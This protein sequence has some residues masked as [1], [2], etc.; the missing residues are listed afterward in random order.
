MTTRLKRNKT[1][2]LDSNKRLRDPPARW[3]KL[4]EIYYITII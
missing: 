2:L 3:K 1:K 4:I